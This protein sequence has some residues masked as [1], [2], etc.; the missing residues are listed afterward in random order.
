MINCNTD[1]E[2][3]GGRLYNGVECIREINVR[4]L[5]KLRDVLYSEIEIHLDFFIRKSHVQLTTFWFG[6]GATRVHALFIRR[7]LYLI[8][9]ASRH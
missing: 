7:A 8:L 4:S 6:S 2:A 9:S 1:D 5:V 3:Y